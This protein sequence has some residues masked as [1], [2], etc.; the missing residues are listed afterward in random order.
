MKCLYASFVIQ[1]NPRTCFVQFLWYKVVPG[2]ALCK[3]RSTKY[4]GKAFVC[5]RICV[6]GVGV[7]KLSAPSGFFMQKISL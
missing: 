6:S 4:C 5:K 1:S 2:S 3:L 7:Q